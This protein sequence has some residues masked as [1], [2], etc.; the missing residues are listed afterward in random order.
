MDPATVRAVPADDQLA[1][2]TRVLIRNFCFEIYWWGRSYNTGV[3]LTV[4]VKVQGEQFFAWVH[5]IEA[6]KGVR[7][8]GVY[9][10]MVKETHAAI[11]DSGAYN[12]ALSPPAPLYL[13]ERR[14]FESPPV[15]KTK[16]IIPTECTPSYD[17]PTPRK[18]RMLETVVNTLRIRLSDFVRTG[19]ALYPHEVTIIIA[20]FNPDYPETLI[21]VESSGEV[22]V[23][24]LHDPRDYDSHKYERQGEY[25]LGQRHHP[26]KDLMRKIRRHGIIREIV[27]SDP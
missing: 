13:E 26:Q 10:G 14:H 15:F 6:G 19:I 12:V 23:V 17:P 9:K 22:F 25:P 16:L 4:E 21:L 1:G 11:I 5:D 8:A 7:M 24:T 20:D 18:E 2:I 3:P 27:L